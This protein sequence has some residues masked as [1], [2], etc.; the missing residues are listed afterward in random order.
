VRVVDWHCAIVQSK[1]GQ[2]YKVLLSLLI[3]FLLSGCITNQYYIVVPMYDRS[4]FEQKTQEFQQT[5]KDLLFGPGF[6]KSVPG[7]SDTIHFLTPD[8]FI[9]RQ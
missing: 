6:Y 5:Q 2:R 4:E 3:L 9:I 7:R 8:D 1:S